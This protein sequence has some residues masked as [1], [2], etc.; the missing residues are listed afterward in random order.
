MHPSNRASIFACACF[1][2]IQLLL[3]PASCWFWVQTKVRCSTRATSEGSERDSTHPGKTCALR[4]NSSLA[5]I[6]SRLSAWNSA[7]LPSHQWIF[8]GR[9]SL[10]TCCTHR[11]T[12][13]FREAR[14]VT[15]CAAVAITV[16][17]R[18]HIYI[19]GKDDR[20]AL[21]RQL[22]GIVRRSHSAIFRGPS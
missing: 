15:C 17:Y 12:A 9:V 6:N 18:E 8:C 7:S 14:E 4:G 3:G 22:P 2:S 10:A 21:P 1:G 13:W 19:G 16:L 11:A 5:L 20:R